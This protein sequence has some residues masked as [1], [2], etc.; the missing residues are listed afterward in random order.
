MPTYDY[1]CQACGHRFERYQTMTA[2]VM[3]K[4]PECGKPRLERLIGTG[5][6]VIFKGSGFY[7]TDYR[8]ASYT[9]A[10]KS[11][12][13]S[14]QP[15]CTPACGTDAAPAGCKKVKKTAGGKDSSSAKPPKP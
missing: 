13:K 15:G 7:G 3:R 8:S 14:E 4:C 11:E 5:A 1:E 12:Q 2:K 9:E 10:Q 6:G